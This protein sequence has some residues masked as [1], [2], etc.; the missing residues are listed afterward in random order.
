[1]EYPTRT[2]KY[3]GAD[4][5]QHFWRYRPLLAW[6][7]DL[8]SKPGRCWNFNHQADQPFILSPAGLSGSDRL[9]D[10]EPLHLVQLLL[11]KY[12]LWP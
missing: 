1:M 9:S 4:G 11:C 7:Q 6:F 10:E 12:Y 5:N 8:P 3:C 2:S